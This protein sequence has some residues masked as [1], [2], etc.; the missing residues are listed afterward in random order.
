MGTL[1]KYKSDLQIALD[2]K[3]LARKAADFFVGY[4]QQTL[5]SNQYFNVAI[6]G[7]QT[8]KLFFEAIAARSEVCWEKINIFWVDERYVPADSSESNYKLAMDLL[9][10]KVPIPPSNIHRIQTEF[11]N[12]ELAVQNYEQIIREVFKLG[13]NQIPKFDLI[14]LGMGADGHTGSLFP[15]SC[16]SFDANDIACVV[17]MLEKKF[18]RITLTY[19]VLRAASSII[20]LVSGE[21]KA[22]ILKTVFE[23]QPDEVKYPIH[24]LWPVLDKVIWFIDKAAAEYL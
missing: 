2:E 23:S 20:V 6:S 3:A 1:S 8:P 16:A 14:V 15:N 24:F 9:L 11:Y 5:K 17:Y 7:G 21:Q 12:F 22:Q 13:E 18:N 10:S 19:P 4:V